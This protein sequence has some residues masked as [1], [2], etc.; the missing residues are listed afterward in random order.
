MFEGSGASG[1]DEWGVTGLY[2]PICVRRIAGSWG[3]RLARGHFR[4]G[5]GTR[6]AVSYPCL[7]CLADVCRTIDL[8]YVRPN[9]SRSTLDFTSRTSPRFSFPNWNGP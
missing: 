2:A 6:N 5:P 1:L 9:W 4:A 8:S 7:R 3:H